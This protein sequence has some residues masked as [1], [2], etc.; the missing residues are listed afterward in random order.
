ML[1][2]CY[3]ITREFLHSNE[4]L[5]NEERG[6]NGTVNRSSINIKIKS[7]VVLLSSKHIIC[8]FINYTRMVCHCLAFIMDQFRGTGLIPS[9]SPVF[10]C[11]SIL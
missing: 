7:F 1:A 3:G 8:G 2:F 9:H 5:Q 6:P 4:V 11:L 10:D